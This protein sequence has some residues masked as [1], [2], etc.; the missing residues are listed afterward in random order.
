[1]SPG[2]PFLARKNRKDHFSFVVPKTR[3][4]MKAHWK[5]SSNAPDLKRKSQGRG[6][7][8]S[9]TTIAATINIT[10]SKSV[11]CPKKTFHQGSRGSAAEELANVT[12]KQTYR[13]AR[14]CRGF[15]IAR[16][17]T[18][19]MFSPAASSGHTSSSV[20]PSV[21]LVFIISAACC[22]ERL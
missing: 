13:Q 18:L 22:H 21:T 8:W 5:Y 7:R 3:T 1:M 16:Q 10:T 6:C 9:R 15:S 19:L 2:R 11:I 12:N 17:P 4:R 20:K 14:S